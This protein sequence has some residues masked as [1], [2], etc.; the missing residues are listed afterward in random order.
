VHDRRPERIYDAIKDA[1]I[2][3]CVSP[4]VKEAVTQKFK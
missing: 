3:L 2:V 1:D 4:I